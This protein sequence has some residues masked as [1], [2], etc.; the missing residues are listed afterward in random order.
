MVSIQPSSNEEGQRRNVR[1]SCKADFRAL[2]IVH[3]NEELE[4]KLRLEHS[5]R[6]LMKDFGPPVL[7]LPCAEALLA[8]QEG[9]AT[10]IRSRI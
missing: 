3:C 8:Q 4:V 5:F 10:Y 7:G 6:G 2:Y 1:S 9:T